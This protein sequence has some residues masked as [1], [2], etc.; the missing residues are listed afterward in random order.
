MKCYGK[1]PK[2]FCGGYM[3]I[4]KRNTGYWTNR[5]IHRKGVGKHC[6]RN[7]EKKPEPQR[8]KMF[9]KRNCMTGKIYQFGTEENLTNRRRSIKPNQKELGCKSMKL[10][11]E[12]LLVTGIKEFHSCQR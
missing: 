7:R 2:M 12:Q 6:E 9:F 3:E 8:V 10:F 11:L 4:P 1:M 5:I